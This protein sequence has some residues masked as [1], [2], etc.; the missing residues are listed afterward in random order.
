MA[1]LTEAKLRAA[2]EALGGTLEVDYGGRRE[3]DVFQAVAPYGHHWSDTGGPHLVSPKY[4]S[5]YHDLFNRVQDGIEPCTE[6]CDCWY[7]VEPPSDI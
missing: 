1:R 5:E 2:I 7:G 3:G 6:E 4:A